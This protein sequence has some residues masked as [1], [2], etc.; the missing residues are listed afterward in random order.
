MVTVLGSRECVGFAGKWADKMLEEHKGGA[1]EENLKD[2]EGS[3]PEDFWAGGA[4]VSGEEKNEPGVVP[5][6]QTQHIPAVRKF[7]LL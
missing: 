5:L 1:R 2:S 7:Q 3:F 6:S 4:G